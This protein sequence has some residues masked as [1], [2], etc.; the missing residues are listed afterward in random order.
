MT[1][2]FPEIG[3]VFLGRFRLERIVG[4]GGYGR[5]Y[6]ARQLNIDRTVALKIVAPPKSDPRRETTTLAARFEL[7]AKAISRLSDPHTIKMY[8]HG[9][10]DGLLYMVLE[11]VDGR[12]LQEEVA[13]N[14]AMPAYRVVSIVDQVLQSLGEAHRKGVLHRDVKPG[15]IMIYNRDGQDDQVK[16]LDFGLAK[17][18][19]GDQQLSE[20]NLTADDILI[21][22][23]RYMSPEQ[24][25]GH[26][27]E[28]T[29]DLY[30]LGL[31]AIELLS[32]EQLIKDQSA[33]AVVARHI[34]ATEFDLSH[35]PGPPVLIDVLAKMVRKR[36]EDRFQS[37]D[38]AR[39]ALSQWADSPAG[40]RKQP[41]AVIA[42]LAAT[43]LVV[44]VVAL[45]MWSSDDATEVATVAPAADAALAADAGAV[46]VADA[47]AP[48][49]VDAGGPDEFDPALLEAVVT[50]RARMGTAYRLAGDFADEAGSQKQKRRRRVR[51]D[52]SD[53][54]RNNKTTGRNLRIFEP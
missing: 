28:P 2:S 31:T 47:G 53:K 9:E 10:L 3:D 24:V 7:E 34:A 21:G 22:T 32:G 50:A 26:E 4:F 35:L 15:N 8:E 17:S 46:T 43:L 19:R 18:L 54:D 48:V 1:S 37:V 52:H 12:S 13:I 16:V 5:I 42:L 27:L 23:P 6:E 39:L 25:R 38:E 44:A 36:P 14:G 45:T 33:M 49:V 29:S 30:S 11:F 51:R 40:K 41:V 20:E